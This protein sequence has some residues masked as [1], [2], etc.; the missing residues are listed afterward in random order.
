MARYRAD[1]FQCA[2]AI[3]IQQLARNRTVA[4]KTRVTSFF[5]CRATCL[6]DAVGYFLGSSAQSPSTQ[7]AGPVGSRSP[8]GLFVS[9]NRFK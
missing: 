2:P 3:Q 9:S 5:I 1:T 7:S 8:S 4:E 6:W